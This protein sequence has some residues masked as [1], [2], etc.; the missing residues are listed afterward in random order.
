MGF[1]K[2]INGKDKLSKNFHPL[3]YSRTI[4]M[5]KKV[6]SGDVVRV[7]DISGNFIAYGFYN[8]SSKIA[9]RLLKWDERKKIN[10]DWFLSKIESS[11]FYRKILC[12]EDRTNCYRFIFGEVDGLPGIV[13][14]KYN[15]Y[16]YV[17]Q[18]LSK[19]WK[20]LL[21]FQKLNLNFL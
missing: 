6:K 8:S 15:Y 3:I 17:L 7:L 4:D 5:V 21:N 9:V 10:R 12:M 19:A 18:L 11:F 13:L 14:D 16:Y 2:L 20:I 1:F